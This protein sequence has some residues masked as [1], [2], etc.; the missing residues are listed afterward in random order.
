MAVVDLVKQRRVA[1]LDQTQKA[2]LVDLREQ[3]E[4]VNAALELGLIGP[5]PIIEA[6][7]R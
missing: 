4:L 2:R 3:L 1:I 6:G 7:C 5:F